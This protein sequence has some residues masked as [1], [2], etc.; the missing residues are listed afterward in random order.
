MRGIR[1]SSSCTTSNRR[2]GRLRVDAVFG[3]S[4]V[5]SVSFCAR[6]G[7]RG[8]SD[9]RLRCCC[10]A[11]RWSHQHFYSLSLF[12]LFGETTGLGTESRTRGDTS[13]VTQRSAVKQRNDKSILR[14]YHKLRSILTSFAQREKCGLFWVTA[15]L[16]IDEEKLKSGSAGGICMHQMI[17]VGVIGSYDCTH[18]CE[19]YTFDVWP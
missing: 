6:N 12:L 2:W 7:F 13:C 4:I 1:S 8:V 18:S 16:N 3:V 10:Y 9:C 19:V 11:V 17:L 15:C 14:P 5:L